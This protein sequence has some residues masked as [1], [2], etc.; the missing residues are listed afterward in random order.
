MQVV[1]FP[2]H[3][4]AV[5]EAA[6]Q[7][8]VDEFRVAWPAAWPTIESAH[9][10]VTTALQTDKIALAA[11]AD[12]GMLIGWV[13]AQSQ[14]DGAVWELHPLVV[15]SVSHGQGVGRA[16]VQHL[17]TEVSERGG[18]TL[19]VGTDDEANLTSL[20]GIDLY[21]DVLGKLNQI[22]N[23]RRHPIGFYW[24]LGFEVIGVMPDANG[25][26]KPDI[27]MAKRVPSA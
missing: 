14:Y 3:D 24:R 8:L 27:F 10:E 13:G 16:L 22:E 1:T 11:L 25:F 15:R 23:L 2:A 7:L 12:E 4:A 18:I 5:R 26:G 6:A 17:E 21:P 20:G 9:E 19:W